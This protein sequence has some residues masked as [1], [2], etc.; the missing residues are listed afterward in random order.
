MILRC[1]MD[2]W[3]H[4][5]LDPQDP[6]RTSPR[7]STTQNVS[8]YCPVFSGWGRGRGNHPLRPG[9]SW[10]QT[11]GRDS[12]RCP[13][14]CLSIWLQGG[15]I[16]APRAPGLPLLSLPL[17]QPPPPSAH[18]APSLPTLSGPPLPG[19]ACLSAAALAAGLASRSSGQIFTA[20]SSPGRTGYKGA[21]GPRVTRRGPGWSQAGAG[22]AGPR[23]RVPAGRAVLWPPCT[24]LSDPC[25]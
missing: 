6:S 25:L 15:D 24:A 4:P 22:P 19:P 20:W 23:G 7:I 17:A 10:L 8:R 13:S 11:G 16:P 21:E 9:V 1:G 5:C 3:P 2:S 12:R 14:G 18:Q